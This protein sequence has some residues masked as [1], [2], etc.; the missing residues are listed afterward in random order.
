MAM[1]WLQ[2]RCPAPVCSSPLSFPKLALVWGRPRPA[3]IDGRPLLWHGRTQ[4]SRVRISSDMAVSI[5]FFSSSKIDFFFF[6]SPCDSRKKTRKDHNRL[7]KKRLGLGRHRLLATSGVVASPPN[8]PTTV[9]MRPPSVDQH[10]VL[11]MHAPLSLSPSRSLS[12]LLPLSIACLLP[13]K[14]L[15]GWIFYS[16]DLTRSSPQSRPGG[17]GPLPPL[18]GLWAWWRG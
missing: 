18:L 6:S 10:R 11:K 17:G 9:Y 7:K 4:P 16:Q 14:L 8:E 12:L 1:A 15:G 2:P 5:C 13:Q 3:S